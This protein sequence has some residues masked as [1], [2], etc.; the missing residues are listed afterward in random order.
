MGFLTEHIALYAIKATPFL[1]WWATEL[2]QLFRPLLDHLETGKGAAR[3]AI[4]DDHVDIWT[5]LTSTESVRRLNIAAP[6]F[7]LNTV[8]CDELRSA[9]EGADLAI[10]L[11]DKEV[12]LLD[13][14]PIG[15]GVPTRESL[16]Y[17][18]LQE[19][20]IEVER[21]AFTWRFDPAG[22]LGSGKVARIQV[23][24]CRQEYLNRIWETAKRYGLTPSII[25]YTSKENGELEFAFPVQ[26]T[27]NVALSIQAHLNRILLASALSLPFI[28]M[29]L[30]GT[31]A[32]IELQ[33]SRQELASQHSRLQE[34]EVLMRRQAGVSAIH[35][36]LKREAAI[37]SIT[38]ALNELGRLLP[39]N[40]W[41]TELRLEGR[42]L[43]I[44]GLSADPAAAAK[45]VA[46]CGLLS[47]IRLASVSSPNSS[48]AVSQ[49]EITAMLVEKP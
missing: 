42:T 34:S 33:L 29:I 19:S 6:F 28:A 40:T 1:E 14:R 2:R 25:G 32:T 24:L 26:R 37:P 5:R 39:G 48:K 49:F 8:Q 45:A 20:P 15:T 30:A 22:K 41:S 36:T 17:R 18:L 23:A 27:D 35:G 11:P 13:L 46:P 43:H 47:D 16:K 4:H 38:N 3:I 21:V 44:T 31:V 10:C 12:H 7:D 9:A